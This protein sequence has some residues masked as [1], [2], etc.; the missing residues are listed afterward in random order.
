MLQFS[1]R[2][3]LAADRRDVATLA[4]EARLDLVENGTTPFTLWN[5]AVFWMHKPA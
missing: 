4:N 2:G 5:G 1:Y 3:D